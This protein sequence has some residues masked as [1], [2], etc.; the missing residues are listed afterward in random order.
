MRESGRRSVRRA[1][2]AAAL[3][4]LATAAA[5]PARAEEAPAAA[6]EVWR[7][8]AGSSVATVEVNRTALLPVEGVFRYSVLNGES[9][10][11]TDTQIARASLFYPGE[12]L[13][14]GPNL[15]CG[16]FGNQFPPE[17]KPVLDTCLSYD[18]P[19]TV[20]ADSSTPDKATPGALTLG[21]PSDPVTGEVV[22]AKAHAAPD[23]ASTSSVMQDLR[24]LGL[25]AIDP[26][27]LLPLQELTL[28]PTVVSVASATSRT[29]QRIDAGKLV[30]DAVSE[31]SGVRLLGGLVRIGSIRSVSSASDDGNGNRTADASLEV[32]GVT[33]AGQPA[34]ITDQGLVLGPPTGPLDQ[35][36]QDALNQ[37]L[38]SFNVKVTLLD[39]TET[40]D[41]G[42]GLARA[43]AGGVLVE[44]SVNV[45]GA[46]AVP[47]PMGDIDLSGTYVGSVLLGTSGAAAGA[48]NAAVDDLGGASG[49]EAAL[50]TGTDVAVDFGAP[51]APGPGAAGSEGITGRPG[52]AGP[53][54]GGGN[55]G[56]TLAR[57]T[58]PFG[59][60]IGF[61]YLAFMFSV[62]GLAVAPRFALAARLP[63]SR[64]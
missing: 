22:S 15:A 45:D 1:C 20:R 64:P 61:V 51:G 16:T 42:T 47:G 53:R 7:G 52:A 11:E 26:F 35:Q 29:S 39:A 9:T 4:C 6:P 48:Q 21:K 60:R 23:G 27:P 38:A 57:V 58:D 19:L 18:Y 59:G 40:K 12:G 49:G 3:A 36:L 55:G 14:Q 30:V 33:V 50:P 31:L 10:Y 54:A 17:F 2:F 46:P 62:L 63:R 24:V 28:D 44:G 32:S 34:Q 25:P 43:S 56:L 13:I 41:D 5:I 8:S 37:V